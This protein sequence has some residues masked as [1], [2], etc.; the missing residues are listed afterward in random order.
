MAPA[1]TFNI[2]TRQQKQQSNFT[3]RKIPDPAGPFGLNRSPPHH[4]LLRL[5][6]FPPNLQDL[7]VV[8]SSAS[9]DIGLFSRSKV[10][11]APNKPADQ[12]TG[13]FTLT[14][15]S[16]DSRRAALP[17][18]ADLTDTSPIGFALDLS[19]KET[20]EK[21]I[22]GDEMDESPTPVPAL[23]ALNNEG[24][25]AAWWIIYLDSIRQGTAYPG[26]VVAE[27]TQT[28]HTPTPNSTPAPAAAPAFGTPAQTSFGSTAF[29]SPSA[30]SPFGAARPTTAFGTP[31]L[32]APSAGAF[33]A[34]SELGKSQSPWAANTTPATA[35]NGPAFGSTSF[36]TTPAAPKPA[37][38][39]PTFGATSTPA[40]GNRAS[41]WA[42]GGS[43]AP[44]AAF[45]QSGGLGKQSS[46][47]GAPT[48]PSS[49]AP[50]SSGFAAF[51]LK[52]GFGNTTAAAPAG[53]SIFGSASTTAP[54]ASNP[55]S[56]APTNATFGATPA[57]TG[58]P[59][60]TAPASNNSLFG[61]T[62]TSKPAG[63]F[64][65]GFVLNS[66]FKADTSAEDDSQEAPSQSGGFF[67][68]NFKNALGETA[69]SS[70]AEVP[71][72]K[73]ADMDADDDSNKE[74]S[75]KPDST[76]PA[77]TPA[78]PKM[79]LFG[80]STPARG[81]TFGAPSAQPSTGMSAGF[82]FGPLSDS[83]T[84]SSP[85]NSF[86]N[87]NQSTTPGP[88][89]SSLAQ[90]QT[91][92]AF[93]NTP[94]SP[95]V[96][97]EPMPNTPAVSKKIPE[98]PLPPDTTSKTSY[99][100]GDSSVSSVATEAPLPPDF[101]TSKPKQVAPSSS[102]AIPAPK[103][104]P[105][106]TVQPSDVPGGPDDDGSD[107]GFLTEE[108]GDESEGSGEP[109]EEGSGED[110]GKDLSPTPETNQT[111][112]LSPESSFGGFKSRNPEASM[113]TKISKPDQATQPRSG[114]FG[115]L[116]LNAPTLPPPKVQIS[117]RSPSPVR[118][119]I[120]GRLHRP[121]ASRSS[122]AP[123]FASQL[124][125]SQRMSARPSGPSQDT[126]KQTQE[127]MQAEQKRRQDVRARQ[128]AEETQSLYDEVDAK[129][130]AEMDAPI[131]PSKKLADFETHTDYDGKSLMENVPAQIEAVFRDINRM[132]D[133]LG[134]NARSLKCFIKAHEDMYKEAGREKDDLEEDDD[135]CLVEM[136][137]LPKIIE[138][139]LTNDLE[140]AR[141]KDAKAKL[142]ECETLKRDL[143]RLRA[144]SDEVKKI[145]ASHL[146]PDTV[147]I[148]RAQPLSADQ[149]AQQNDLR[150]DFTKFQRLLSEAEEALSV[151]K[152]KTVSHASSN[153]R[154]GGSTGPT[155]EAVMR[156]ITKM[157]SMAEKRSG[158]IDVLEGQMRKLRFGSVGGGSREGSPFATPTNNRA[159]VRN[160]GASSLFY[161]P[162]SVRDS[163][164]RF[165]NSLMS[166]VSSR[167]VSS[168]PRKKL[169]GYSA[170]E[171]G[172]LMAQIARKKEVTEKLKAALLKNGTKVRAMTDDE[173]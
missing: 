4:F 41:P 80:T 42:A 5:R 34:T 108:E 1:S 139:D 32:S 152:A 44:A 2:V 79:T 54:T 131:V 56:S 46:P 137:Q 94:S 148:A 129:F 15:M 9:A 51:A 48:N 92:A 69:K 123:G 124:L 16:D 38:G 65:S 130:R 142:E 78:P 24:V 96:K 105:A 39:T 173:E 91:P 86:G 99:A 87:S 136:E 29:G 21:P 118:T 11:L 68:R 133:T 61:S 149:A 23:M 109:S 168:P 164:D 13:V 6:D 125:G 120:P 62:S 63:A 93:P 70:T 18:T 128:E 100:A 30:H 49:A 98:A 159:S 166:S 127:E 112:A 146:D 150:R 53:G 88:K 140:T 151:L 135:W 26:L 156:T 147:A 95:K 101:L 110:V 160:L 59:F 83:K 37:F 28:T 154:N 47:F 31:A 171:K 158:D 122:S 163:H 134:W 19:S 141:V 7:I 77:S 115:E 8:A 27:G 114:L 33:G 58:S 143:N 167:G 12:I 73:E 14:E 138:N 97:Q 157:T 3:F 35:S 169:S 170:E 57:T 71:V 172:V 82:G 43:T 36:G 165:R 126:L 161:S 102:P 76:T 144:K 106:E 22:V 119:A 162:E 111:P 107:S 90:S 40:L 66:S 117:P 64:G 104:S 45:G 103:A 145:L 81:N 72:S 50:S 121:E 67:G 153:G 89:T 60:G 75:A 74:E 52:G 17:M 25:L 132:I 20:V 113:F 116:A 84:N 10:P 155:V 55:F 85:F